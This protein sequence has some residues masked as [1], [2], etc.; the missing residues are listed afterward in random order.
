MS[1]QE[2]FIIV[3]QSKTRKREPTL[4]SDTLNNSVNK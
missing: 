3:E 1:E 2:F 4:I